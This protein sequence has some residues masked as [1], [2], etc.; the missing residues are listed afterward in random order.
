MTDRKERDGGM[1]NICVA[2]RARWKEYGNMARGA[3]ENE[4]QHDSKEEE[5]WFGE[6]KGRGQRTENREEGSGKKIQRNGED[7]VR[8]EEDGEEGGRLEMRRGE[9]RE[10]RIGR[11]DQGRRYRGMGKIQ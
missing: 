10:Q 3:R 9:D 1:K 2:W 7:T 8:C 6:E 4:Q 5:R 11:K